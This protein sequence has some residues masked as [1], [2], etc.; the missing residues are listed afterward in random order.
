MKTLLLTRTEATDSFT[1]GVLEI[2]GE[3][4]WTT[5]ELP[6]IDNKRE[7][8]CIP[9]G[10]YTCERITSPKFGVT[11]L[12]QDVP[13]RSEIVFH[14]GNTVGDT[15]GCILLGRLYKALPRPHIQAS[16]L[17]F[18]HFRNVLKDE[19]HILLRIQCS[20]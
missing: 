11:W 14:E 16:Q 19:K 15:H 12:L 1:R 10:S 17:A 5:L 3:P 18:N 8:S 9:A 7:I 20:A 13:G 6:W 2:D 4:A